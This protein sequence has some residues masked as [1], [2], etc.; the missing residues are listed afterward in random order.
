MGIK[1]F[2]SICG[3]FQK[4]KIKPV[5]VEFWKKIAKVERLSLQY[6]TT[7][8]QQRIPIHQGERITPTLEP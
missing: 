6:S 2:V 8:K 1:N 7:T 5:G 4:K 3:V